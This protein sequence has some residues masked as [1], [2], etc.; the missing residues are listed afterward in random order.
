M[1]APDGG[2]Y[3]ALG[4]AMAPCGAPPADRRPRGARQ[5]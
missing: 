2:D 5:R 3:G 4:M 1:M